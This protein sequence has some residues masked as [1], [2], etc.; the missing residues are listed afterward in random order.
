[1]NDSAIALAPDTEK[2]KAQAEAKQDEARKSAHE[3]FQRD[4]ERRARNARTL[5]EAYMNAGFSEEQAFEL[6][7]ATFISD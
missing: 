4:A 7:V 3:F 5:Y 2:F 6:T 1:M